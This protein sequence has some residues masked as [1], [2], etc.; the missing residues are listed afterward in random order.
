MAK[1]AKPRRNGNRN[2][3]RNPY[4]YIFPR[5]LESGPLCPLY[6]YFSL[7]PSTSYCLCHCHSSLRGTRGSVLIGKGRGGHP[8]GVGRYRRNGAQPNEWFDGDPA[9]N[10]DFWDSMAR[11]VF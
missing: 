1:A 10:S 5:G 9:D 3:T 7:S 6:M 11:K 2:L 4:I 8:T